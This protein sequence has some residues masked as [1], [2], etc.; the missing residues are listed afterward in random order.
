MFKAL[1][2]Y[3]CINLYITGLFQ[4]NFEKDFCGMQMDPTADF[5]FQRR[6]GPT[7]T[8]MTGPNAD[9]SSGIGKLKKQFFS[10][11]KLS[12]PRFTDYDNLFWNLQTLLKEVHQKSEWYSARM[13]IS[14]YV[15]KGCLGWY[16]ILFEYNEHGDFMECPV[17]QLFHYYQTFC[18][19]DTLIRKEYI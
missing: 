7:S 12:I 10:N 18:I 11:Q 14:E 13:Y 2:A 4:C 5:E 16:L 1:H 8:S 6:R 15:I 9:Y 17:L 19:N 3:H